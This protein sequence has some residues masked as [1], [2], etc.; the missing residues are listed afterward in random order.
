MSM[1]DV[2]RAISDLQARVA[3]LEDRV[4][5]GQL[6]ALYGPAVDSGSAAVTAGLWIE[7]GS[8][9]AGIVSFED[10]AAIGRMVET[11]PHQQFLRNGAAH[12]VS[13]PV[14]EIS[15]DT[16]AATSYQ[17]VIFRDE[18]ADGYRIWRTSANR[19]EFERT[20]LGWRVARRVNRPLDGTATARDILSQAFDEA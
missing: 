10:A 19:W 6:M 8:Y 3:E 9:D 4:A 7:S 11:D 12:I 16:A 14:I 13:T 18:A 15:G 17:L 20:A 2:D 1:N 5:I